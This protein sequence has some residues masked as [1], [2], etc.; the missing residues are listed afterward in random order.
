MSEVEP[1]SCLSAVLK[2][3]NL[4]VMAEGDKT[5]T[6]IVTKFHSSRETNQ[7]SRETNQSS[8]DSN[9]SSR[10]TTPTSGSRNLVTKQIGRQERVKPA[11]LYRKYLVLFPIPSGKSI[12]SV[13][14]TSVNDQFECAQIR[15]L[16][17]F[18]AKTVFNKY[19]LN[20]PVFV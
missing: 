18:L 3:K 11:L 16:L 13:L 4:Q 9:Q 1:G 14:Q 19:S 15:I 5:S 17:E 2:Y 8:R 7:S 20:S 12:I 6:E 10:E